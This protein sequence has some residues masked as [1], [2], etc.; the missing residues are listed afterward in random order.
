VQAMKG[1]TSRWVQMSF[2]ELKQRYWGRHLWAIGY[3]VRTSGNV[4]DEM[5]K[6]Y[7]ERHGQDDKFGNFE[8]GT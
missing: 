4:T 8:V 1:K 7:I 5:I 2:P 3:F 6:Y